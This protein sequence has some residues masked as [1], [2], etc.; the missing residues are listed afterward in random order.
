MMVIA[1]V[2]YYDIVRWVQA[3][4]RLSTTS[5]PVEVE[6]GADVPLPSNVCDRLTRV[7]VPA[8]LSVP[9]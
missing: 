7:Q 6:C 5:I 3:V 4:P 8:R 2:Q 1:Y 9:S